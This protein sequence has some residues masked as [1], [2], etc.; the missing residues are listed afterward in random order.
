MPIKTR[1]DKV[2]SLREREAEKKLTVWTD[3]GRAAKQS[4]LRLRDARIHASADNRK[5]G[6][7][8]E[9]D[10]I[11]MA[12][13]TALVEVRVAE[14]SVQKARAEEAQARQAHLAAHTQ[15]ETM[16]R[17]A[18]TRREELQKEEDRIE[19]RKVDDLT[20]MMFSHRKKA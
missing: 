8:Y 7:A 4:E 5:S 10:V 6:A 3:A 17:V 1:L 12:H 14:Q 19:T 13:R 18:D 2:V 20:S 16:R 11:E 9:W 15:A